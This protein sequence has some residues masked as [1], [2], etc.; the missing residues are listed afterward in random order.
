MTERIRRREFLQ[1]AALAPALV[2]PF[3]D[4]GRVQT[5]GGRVFRPGDQTDAR[6]TDIATLITAKMT[7]YHV[8]GVAL[9]IIKD[10]QLTLRGFGVTNVD[11]PQPILDNT[12]FTIASISKTFTATAV[13]KLVEQGKVELKAPVQKYLPEFRVLD[14]AASREV[15]L[16]HLLTHSPGWEG[17]LSSEDR[18]AEALAHF[19]TTILRDV[20]QLAKPGEVWSYNNAGFS[21][22]GRVIEV[23]TGR[24][25]HDALR[26]LV[27][28]PLGLTRTFTRVQDAMTYR[29]SLGH[30]EQG[31]RTQVIRPY[32]GTSGT[33]AGGVMTSISDLMK[34]ARFHLSDGA[35]LLTRALVDEMKTPQ[36]RKN[37][38][39]DEMGA[40]WHLRKVGGIQTAAH[41]GTLNGHCLLVE[42]VPSRNLAFAILTNHTDGWRLVQDVEAAILKGYESVALGPSQR[43]GHRGVNEAM[44]F[45]SKELATPPNFDQYLGTYRR[46]PNGN[47]VVRHEDGRLIIGGATV[48]FY[49]PD[50]AYATAGA[51]V[52]SP[53][54]FIRTS[55]GKVGWVRV[56]GRI[57]RKEST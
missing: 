10:G 22:A 15:T 46:P 25:I 16:W 52:G 32:Q 44:T 34:Y 40:G 57:A 19:A 4:G 13:M 26:E 18:G 54:E 41:G 55:D 56:N 6:L 14:E 21:L 47:V 45:H 38:T 48:A 3:I 50:V 7:E 2:A 39:D 51:Y 17:Q 5:D 42:L 43:I 37:S 35:P 28:T 49:G 29:L 27:F 31:G 24:G 33:T 12:I 20:P 30:R 11:D 9:G 36:L 8:P 1:A 23:V 53:Y